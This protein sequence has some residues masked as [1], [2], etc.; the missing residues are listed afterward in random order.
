MEET[1]QLTTQK[2]ALRMIKICANVFFYGLILLII[3]FS[4]ANIRGKNKGNVP[5]LFGKG[6]AHVLTDSMNGTKKNSFRKGDLAWI[7]TL[8]EKQK[9]NLN[10]DDIILFYSPTEGID[11]THRI[12]AVEKDNRNEIVYITRGDLQAVRNG[13]YDPKRYESI[14]GKAPEL[15]QDFEI[16]HYKNVKG[17]VTSTWSGWGKTLGYLSN[18]RGGFLIWIV[19]PTVLF[20]AF[21]I[22]IL[23]RNIIRYQ[24]DKI[25][26]DAVSEKEK[27]RLELL[28]ELRK[29]QEKKEE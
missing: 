28:E 9:Q 13:E 21:E 27:L 4:I 12:V 23:V 2:Q 19:I 20:L 10:V 16:I 17:R 24:K 8:N 18:P 14:D 29:E 6:Y 25:M 22:F 3:L 7:K 5:N 1:K 11:I 26:E 15:T